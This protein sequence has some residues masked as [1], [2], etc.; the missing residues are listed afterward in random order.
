M[1]GEFML[2]QNRSGKSSALIVGV[3]V[4]FL[5][6]IG[7]GVFLFVRK[8]AQEIKVPQDETLVEEETIESVSELIAEDSFGATLY[9]G[10]SAENNNPAETLPQNNPFEEANTNVL[11]DVYVNPFE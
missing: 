5:I 7:V 4:A 6:I 8:D 11:E 2:K 1:D 3:I 10:V 9:E